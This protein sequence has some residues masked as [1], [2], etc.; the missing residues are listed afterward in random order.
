M[1]STTQFAQTLSRIA[2]QISSRKRTV[3]AISAI[4][5][6][7]AAL[8]TALFGRMA[9]V[10]QSYL[11]LIAQEVYLGRA[12]YTQL[13]DLQPLSSI[14]I[15]SPAIVLFRV[16]GFPVMEGWNL[17]LVVLSAVS[18]YLF[19]MRAE[20][21]N[22]PAFMLVWFVCLA[23]GFDD[24]LFGQRDFFFVVVWFPYVAARLSGTGKGFSV[25]DVV[26][27]LLL[28]MIVCA[29]PLFAIFVLAIDLPIL[30][31]CRKRQAFTP[32]IALVA[33]GVLQLLHF[34]LLEPVSE[35]FA[36]AAKMDY[37]S[38]VGYRL[39]PSLIAFF[40]TS[41][42][43]VLAV[44]IGI[45]LFVVP[46][47]SKLG[48]FVLACGMTGLLS[49]IIGILQGHPRNYY[50]IPVVTAA[51]AAALYATFYKPD[52]STEQTKSRGTVRGA[53][54]LL[55]AALVVS[56]V[57]VFFMEGGAGR[58]LWKKYIRGYPDTARIGQSVK[59]PYVDWVQQHV[60]K[61][62][63]V[64]VIA[65]QYGTTSAWDPILSTLRLGRRVN[66]YAPV[67]QFPLRGDL[68]SGDEQRISKAWDRLKEEI[69][70]ANSDWVIIRRTAPEPLEPDFLS[71]IRKHPHFHDWLVANFPHQEQFGEYV[72][73]RRERK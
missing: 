24:H 2:G 52:D 12:Q 57:Q 31:F 21:T 58:A 68:V 39:L 5:V 15:H 30:L 53:S 11:M 43:Y 1:Q 20:V 7:G 28:S 46:R 3:V 56:I 61:D 37:Y 34:F 44:V 26:L 50:F 32:F 60:R 35:Y 51:V 36:L 71:L 72:A 14:Y 45:L 9:G 19:G 47:R 27:G 13:L 66:S 54:L 40:G 55:M 23:L 62:E 10:D 38:T 67:L 6:V 64:S 63:E 22:R 48:R 69:T 4:A 49:F 41:E 25:A 29:K 59:D 17:Y 8:A 16:F 73:F 42:I 18:A 33:G 70:S 65:L